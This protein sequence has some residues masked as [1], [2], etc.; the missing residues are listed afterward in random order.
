MLI[1]K[2]NRIIIYGNVPI[3]SDESTASEESSSQMA[4]I[5]RTGL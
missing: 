1:I 5:E 2:G 4:S 3:T